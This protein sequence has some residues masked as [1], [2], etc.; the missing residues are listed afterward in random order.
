MSDIWVTITVLL[1]LIGI[2]IGHNQ[3]I[4]ALAWL[5]TILAF[6]VAL[7]VLHSGWQVLRQNVPWLVDTVAIPPEI[8]AQIVMDVP[9]VLNCHDIASRG[10][11][12]RQVF[13][14]MHLVVEATDVESAHRITEAVEACLDA[15]FS[16]V[17][18]MIH[19]EPPDYQSENLFPNP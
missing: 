17:R 11:V 8:I 9:G 3:Q 19:V 1:G 13:I 10:V 6:P 5:D 12:G 15:K 7:L 16:P 4:P 14:E 18:V 2:W